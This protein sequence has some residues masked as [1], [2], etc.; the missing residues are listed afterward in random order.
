MSRAIVLLQ[1]PTV[2]LG[3]D[4]VDCFAAW[5]SA[6]AGLPEHVEN[7]SD[8]KVRPCV[9]KPKSRLYCCASHIHLR[10]D[11]MIIFT[12]QLRKPIA[13]SIIGILAANAHAHV[14]R[15]GDQGKRLLLRTKAY[16]SHI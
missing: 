2:V 10:V 4:E 7:G 16:S 14:Q 9:G 15:W 1:M 5:V 3:Q 11:L 12:D 13:T 6:E 8:L